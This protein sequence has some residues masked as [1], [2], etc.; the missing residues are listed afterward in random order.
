MNREQVSPAYE[1]ACQSTANQFWAS[2]KKCTLH[3]VLWKSSLPSLATHDI[4]LQHLHKSK[5]SNL[6]VNYS[7]FRE[8]RDPVLDHV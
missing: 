2:E 4:C 1:T 3:S 5:Y 7:N 6:N 8:H